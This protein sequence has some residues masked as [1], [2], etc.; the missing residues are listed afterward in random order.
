MVLDQEANMR[1]M[2]MLR[3]KMY[4]QRGLVVL[5][6]GAVS[7]DALAGEGW[8]IC[9]SW[10]STAMINAIVDTGVYG[11]ARQPGRI[12]NCPDQFE[13]PGPPSVS[14]ATFGGCCLGALDEKLAM[15]AQS[16][17]TARTARVYPDRFRIQ[18]RHHHGSVP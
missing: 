16:D 9:D 12:I 15:T 2:R 7:T 10:A 14:H 17:T 5:N 18:Y 8:R 1:P 4:P 11:F 3:D 6:R 13:P